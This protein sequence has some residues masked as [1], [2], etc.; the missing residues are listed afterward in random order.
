MVGLEKQKV[1]DEFTKK[2]GQLEE[3]TTFPRAR[4]GKLKMVLSRAHKYY[5]ARIVGMP[6]LPLEPRSLH[7]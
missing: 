3:S 4:R 5:D 1:D 6:L 2:D 7:F